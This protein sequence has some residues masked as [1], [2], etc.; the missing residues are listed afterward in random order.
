MWQSDVDVADV[1]LSRYLHDMFYFDNSY[2]DQT[3]CNIYHN[4]LQLNKTNSWNSSTSFL[5]LHITIKPNS[6]HTKI[7]DLRD[8]FDLSKVKC[9]RLDGDILR[10]LIRFAIACSN[11]KVK[12]Y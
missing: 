1:L 12:D 8:D 5:D 11:V 3:V 4:E 7:Y 10:G 6:I 9:P 2:F